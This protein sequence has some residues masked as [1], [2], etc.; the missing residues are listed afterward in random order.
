MVN[1]YEGFQGGAPIYEQFD[2]HETSNVTSMASGDAS[3]D[4]PMNTPMDTPMDQNM[5]GTMDPTSMSG[6]MDPVSAIQNYCNPVSNPSRVVTDSEG[7]ETCQNVPL[8]MISALSSEGFTNPEDMSMIQNESMPGQEESMPGQEESEEMV[9]GFVGSS[10]S[11][12][13]VNVNLLLKALLFACIFYVLAHPDTY[14]KVI[15]KLHKGITKNNGLYVS[16]VV[17]GLLY[18]VLNLLL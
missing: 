9:E 3:M 5:S 18:Y 15:K 16:M 13:L 6:T 11:R 1:A 7:V 10:S 4:T 8:D 12:Q 17:F 2:D 14:S